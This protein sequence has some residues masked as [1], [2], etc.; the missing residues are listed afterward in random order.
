MDSAGWPVDIPRAEVHLELGPRRHRRMTVPAG[1]L[2]FACMFLPAVKGCGSEPIYPL[3]MPFFWHPYLYG[4]A[5]GFAALASTQRALVHAT[6]VVRALSA[7]V[8]AAS[9][10]LA[11]AEPEVGVALLGI[12]AVLFGVIGTNGVSEKRL[13]IIGILVACM[14]LLWFGLWSGAADALIG[15]YL[16][17][18]AAIFLLAGSLYWL[19]EI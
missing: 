5:L 4:A 12:A 14:S 1:A 7:L 6:R 8:L 15:V 10:I 17:F 9:L 16:S 3:E 2:L 11:V 18:G 19:S 13:A